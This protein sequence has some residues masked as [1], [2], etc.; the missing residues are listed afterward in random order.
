MVQL[1]TVSGAIILRA[2][3]FSLHVVFLQMVIADGWKSLCFPRVFKTVH[4]LY[5]LGD[6][7]GEAN[8]HAHVTCSS[9]DRNVCVWQFPKQGEE[10]LITWTLCLVATALEA[11]WMRSA[12]CR[13]RMW[14]PKISPVSLR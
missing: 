10:T 6:T 12:A 13:P 3:R 2:K 5:L 4:F 11:S 8:M 7:E 9:A 1:E 14:T